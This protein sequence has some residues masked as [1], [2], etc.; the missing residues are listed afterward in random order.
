MSPAVIVAA[1]AG[2]VCLVVVVRRVR[3][4]WVA[5]SAKVDAA[6]AQLPPVPVH[7][8]GLERLLQAVRDNQQ[9]GEQA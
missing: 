9:E 8:A 5:A 3:R 2:V 6:L 1:L 7:D 4:A